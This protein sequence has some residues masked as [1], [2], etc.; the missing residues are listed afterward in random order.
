MEIIVKP[1]NIYNLDKYLKMKA[2]AFIFGIKD[3]SVNAT[4]VVN[5]KSLAYIK[6]KLPEN[7]KIFVSIDKN[8]FDEDIKKLKKILEDLD[9]LNIDG[10]LFYDISLLNLRDSLNLKTP[11]IWNQNFFVVNYKTINYYNDELNVKSCLLSNEI[12]KEEIIEIAKKTKSN[13]FLNVFGYQLM[14]YSKRHL[15]SSYFKNNNMLN[16]KKKHYIKDKT[17]SYMIKE[18][19]HG[20]A[21]ITKN[22]INYI[23]EIDEFKKIGIKYIILD[24][25]NV[26]ND[27]FLKIIDLYSKIVE[28]KKVSKTEI[29]NM[30]SNTTTGFL[31]QKTIY[32]VK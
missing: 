8:I 2:N 1:K 26:P 22:I 6:K 11:F 15:L 20:T 29:D 21:F 32:K 12:T 28:G 19:K 9:N 17:G 23:N 25:K 14:A 5:I 24:E 4:S 7:V 18:E 16:F 31:Y 30:F 27:K 3:Y 13:L 10:T